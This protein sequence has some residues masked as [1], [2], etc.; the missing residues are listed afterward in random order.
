MWGN[1]R[2]HVCASL[3]STLAP[4]DRMLLITLVQETDTD[5]KRCTGVGA[6]IGDT[7]GMHLDS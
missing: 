5:A 3:L 7:V 6:Y 4:G 1:G 2:V